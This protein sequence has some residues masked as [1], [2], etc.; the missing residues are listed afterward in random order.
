MT[1]V[2]AATS[3]PVHGE[4]MII[5][6]E[7]SDELLGKIRS[8]QNRLQGS[9]FNGTQ[10]AIAIQLDSMG[11]FFSDPTS[12]NED[13]EERLLDMAMHGEGPYFLSEEDAAMVEDDGSTIDAPVIEVYRNG[14]R[15]IGEDVDGQ[16]N[17]N[18]HESDMMTIEQLEAGTAKE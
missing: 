8:A 9:E 7:I 16:R 4:H 15:F 14:F 17:I 13:M 2:L 18:R 5:C 1:H 12:A 10:T 6:Y 3:Q 11:F